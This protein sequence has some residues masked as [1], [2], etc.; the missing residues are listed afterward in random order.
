MHCLRL[1]L[2]VTVVPSCT[3]ALD[4]DNGGECK[5]GRSIQ[6]MMCSLGVLSRLSNQ[7]LLFEVDS[8]GALIMELKNK[9]EAIPESGAQAADA[10]VAQW[11]ADIQPALDDAVQDIQEKKAFLVSS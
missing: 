9:L 4:L 10:A 11:L 6:L 8:H 5:Q 3:L 7:G 2:R 1:F